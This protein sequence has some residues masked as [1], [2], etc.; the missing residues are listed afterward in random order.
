MFS[1]WTRLFRCFLLPLSLPWNSLAH[2][3]CVARAYGLT[4][5]DGVHISLQ[6]DD[7]FRRVSMEGRDM[8][9]DGKCLIH[10]ST[11]VACNEAFSP[12][13]EDVEFAKRVVEASESSPKDDGVI[14][15]DGRLV[16]DL[17]VAQSRRILVQAQ[18]A[19]QLNYG[20]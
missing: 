16:E 4:C 15:V 11:I 5:L 6:V 14:V 2:I 8:G 17:H 19:G 13:K 9:F 7:E 1:H 10:P 20:D 3:V 18:L 12:S